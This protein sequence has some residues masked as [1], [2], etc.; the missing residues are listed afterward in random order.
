MADIVRLVE[1]VQ[2]CRILESLCPGITRLLQLVRL[3]PAELN[4]H[5][6]KTKTPSALTISFENSPI[7]AAFGL[8]KL[9]EQGLAIVPMEWDIHV[10]RALVG[11][12]AAGPPCQ[13]TGEC[14]C[15]R[16]CLLENIVD[17]AVIAHGGP[18]VLF[19]E[20][21]GLHSTYAAV[22]RTPLHQ[23]GGLLV[24]HWLGTFARALDM[25]AAA[26]QLPR[27]CGG[28]ASEHHAARFGGPLRVVLDLKTSVSE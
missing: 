12:W 28:S 13:A 23:L 8:V 14:G 26:S 2:W 10:D 18:M 27:P 21:L 25:Y 20:L 9:K 22:L 24:P 17:T 19:R 6:K 11:R 1:D 5:V 7:T 16:C 15:P 4:E 3:I